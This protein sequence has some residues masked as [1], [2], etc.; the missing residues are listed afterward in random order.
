[1]CSVVVIVVIIIASANL[2]ANFAAG[3]FGGMDVDVGYAG[4]DGFEDF[5]KFAGSNALSIGTDN[6]LGGDGAGDGAAA[7]GASTGG[8]RGIG[9]VAEE[10]HDA[11]DDV[12]LAEVDMSEERI[13]DQTGIGKFEG[14]GTLTI[15]GGA[16][17]TGSRGGIRGRFVEAF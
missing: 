16:E 9:V 3:K 10:D 8:M 15:D 12:F 7:Q 6:I 14:D 1:M 4:V 11:T 5:G 17:G 13:G 2:T